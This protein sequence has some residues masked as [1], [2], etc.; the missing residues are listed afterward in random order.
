MPGLKRETTR[1]VNLDPLIEHLI[2]KKDFHFREDEQYCVIRQARKTMEI[3]YKLSQGSMDEL[4]REAALKEAKLK[5][6]NLSYV[7]QQ[8]IIKQKF[9]TYRRIMFNAEEIRLRRDKN[10]QILIVR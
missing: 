2:N 6:K 4:G 10:G 9:D 1:D 3:N 7:K 5:T 8:Q